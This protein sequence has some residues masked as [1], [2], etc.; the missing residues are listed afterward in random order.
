MLPYSG[1]LTD[2]HKLKGRLFFAWMK[3]PKKV[4]DFAN[5]KVNDIYY[6]SFYVSFIV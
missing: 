3:K 1:L 4:V 2:A 6:G 5:Q